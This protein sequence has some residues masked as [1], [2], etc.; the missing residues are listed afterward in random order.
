MESL[1]INSEG[2]IR[3]IS[4]YFGGAEE[5]DIP[6]MASFGDSDNLLDSDPVCHHPW[7]NSNLSC[8]LVF[9]LIVLSIFSFTYAIPFLNNFTEMIMVIVIE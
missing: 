8:F 5:E 7:S 1:S 9:W 2:P 6:D 4:T 3:S